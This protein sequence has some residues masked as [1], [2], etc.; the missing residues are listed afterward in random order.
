M[1]RTDLAIEGIAGACAA[2]GTALLMDRLKP[3][4]RAAEAAD[5]DPD[6]PPMGA[7]LLE[8]VLGYV[9]FRAFMEAARRTAH[10]AA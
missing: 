5:A 3:A 7:K 2:I 6:S 1:T 10:A 8:G 9:V 4:G